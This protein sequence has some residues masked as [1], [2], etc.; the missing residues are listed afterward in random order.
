MKILRWVMLC[1]FGLLLLTTL[2]LWGVS[3]Y[4]L[5][6]MGYRADSFG[7]DFGCG[8]GRVGL[9]WESRVPPFGVGGFFCSA[10]EMAASQRTFIE[11]MYPWGFGFPVSRSN[12]MAVVIPCWLPAVLLAGIETLIIWRMLRAR[13]NK[14]ARAFPVDVAENKSGGPP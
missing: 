12:S 11:T 9:S 8:M 13:R 10:D 14:I 6:K 2:T 3:Y 4:R 7:I 5:C 1:I